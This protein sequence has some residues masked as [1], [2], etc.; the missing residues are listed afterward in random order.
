MLINHTRMGKRS[1]LKA[2][3]SAPI[4]VLGAS[5]LHRPRHPSSQ[6]FSTIILLVNVLSAELAWTAHCIPYRY[7]E[8]SVLCSFNPDIDSH[9][10]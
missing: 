10:I 7:K 4:F 1:L 6:W 2:F 8:L 3:K 9:F 5:I